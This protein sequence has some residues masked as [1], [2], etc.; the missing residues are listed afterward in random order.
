[1]VKAI[2][3][4]AKDGRGGYIMTNG[5]AWQASMQ[6][7]LVNSGSLLNHINGRYKIDRR[8]DYCDQLREPPAITECRLKIKFRAEELNEIHPQFKG[9][10]DNWKLGRATKR[11][12][13]KH[14][15]V[16]A[17]IGDYVLVSPQAHILELEGGHQ[18]CATIFSLRTNCNCGVEVND[19]EVL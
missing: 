4:P 5:V 9:H 18:F 2:F 13:G 17:E 12:M 3:E 16:H 7:E 15:M 1:M 14:N 10:W 6:V 8:T 19:I 11:C